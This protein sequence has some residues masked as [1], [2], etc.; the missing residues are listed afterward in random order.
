MSEEEG[1]KDDEQL[2]FTPQ[3]EA[4]GYISLDQARVRAIEHARDNRE[5][6]GPRYSQGE[7]V[8]EVLS[9]EESEDYHDIRLSFRPAAEFSG[10]PGVEQ[11]TIDKTGP[12]TLRQLLSQPK[13]DTRLKAILAGLGLVTVIVAIVGG[14]AGAGVFSGSSPAIDEASSNIVTVTPDTP[15]IMDSFDGLVTVQMPAG[16]VDEPMLLRY[17]PLTLN[18]PPRLPDGFETTASN[19]DL[20]LSEE[21]ETVSGPVALNT[22]ITVT[23]NLTGEVIASTEGRETNPVTQHYKDGGGWEELA[24][25]VDFGAST[26]SAQV[27]SLSLFA[28]TLRKPVFSLTGTDTPV[29]PTPTPRPVATATPPRRRRPRR[30]LPQ[31]RYQYLLQP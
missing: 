29:L 9:Q 27:D 11:F 3:G 25:T 20:A 14:L 22:P 31:R 1:K 12:I 6:Y 4:L 16:T 19:F 10:N 15:V 26:A 24:T 30:N 8:W 13:P 17:Q 5:I 23:V 18:Q 28:L 2:E 21:G 7:M